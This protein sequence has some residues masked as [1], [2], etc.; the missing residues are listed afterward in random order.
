MIKTTYHEISEELFERFKHIKLVI[1]DVDGVLSDGKIYLTEHGDEIKSFNAKDGCGIVT[2]IK[3]GIEFAVITGRSSN[4]L[5]RRMDNLKVKYVYQGIS[6]KVEAFQQLLD[7]LNLHPE[8]T[9]YI[10]DD[11][12]DL[13][14]L[15]R[16]GISICVQD[17]HP[18]LFDQVDLITKNIG[19]NGAV[20]EITDIILQAH[21]KLA[22][23]ER[24]I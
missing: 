17:A 7:T 20:R 12:I 1:S 6:D 8:E 5:Q 13:P 2:I 4:L 11:V 19:G 22:L 18:L 9:L 14:L 21:G 15:E 10:G 24:S 16:V 3:Q 23:K